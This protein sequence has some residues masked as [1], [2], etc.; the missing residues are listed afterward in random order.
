MNTKPIHTV[1]FF[2]GECGLCILCIR[3]LIRFDKYKVLTYGKIQDV[4][5]QN[6]MKSLHLDLSS[7][8]SVVWVAK[9]ENTS[10]KVLIKSDAVLA[11]IS[12]CGWAGKSLAFCLKLWPRFLRD[13]GYGIIAYGRRFLVGPSKAY[14]VP[15]ELRFRSHA[16]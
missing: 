7:I 6:Y 2:D 3:A 16:T 9:K 1:L 14:F 5:Y 12:C 13:F 11:A 15:D 8:D 4:D 10:P